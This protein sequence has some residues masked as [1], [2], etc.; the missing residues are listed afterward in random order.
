MH[1]VGLVMSTGVGLAKDTWAFTAIGPLAMI[2]FRYSGQ[3]AGEDASRVKKDAKVEQEKID[4]SSAV[5][6]V[7]SRYKAD[8]ILY[9]FRLLTD[10]PNFLSSADERATVEARGLRLETRLGFRLTDGFSA[11]VLIPLMQVSRHALVDE[12]DISDASGAAVHRLSP[13]ET[14]GLIG[15]A[16]RSLVAFVR[17]QDLSDDA[18]QRS[19][20]E[21]L[22]IACGLS[23]R[24]DQQKDN[25][26]CDDTG[27]G[28]H[29]RK[30]NVH[31]TDGE[32]LEQ[33]LNQILAALGITDK[34]WKDRLREFCTGLAKSDLVVVEVERP[35]QQGINL[36]YSQL[37]T[38]ESKR[39]GKLWR[40]RLGLA[41]DT[42]D[43]P[44]MVYVGHAQSYDFQ[45]APLAG[46]Y[47]LNHDVQQLRGTSTE[48]REDIESS[49]GSIDLY[50]NASPVRSHAH[51][52]ITLRD[53]PRMRAT[54]TLKDYKSV[55]DYRE[56][57]PG[58]L[59]AVALMSSAT[60]LLTTFFALSGRD[61]PELNPTL[62][63]AL[64]AFMV[65][66]LGHWWDTS[67]LPKSSVSA[68]L[69]MLGIMVISMLGALL[70]LLSPRH[71]LAWANVQPKVCCGIGPRDTNWLWL[72]LAA[73][74]LWLTLYLWL[75]LHQSSREYRR[76]QQISARADYTAEAA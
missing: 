19:V 64:P 50:K 20:E 55:V 71:V 44:P 1:A 53:P 61:G 35:K 37:L 65:I 12:L 6:A 32:D 34:E 73:F 72:T 3:F 18:A 58:A 67:R 7:L 22:R 29:E 74:A 14:R 25:G 49:L 26:E 27:G 56:T 17:S 48:T 46:Q 63:I 39:S 11:T 31:G 16:V 15:W 59:G 69:G 47:V 10:L 57:P 13:Y 70:Y 5:E 54:R 28:E 33:R 36:S 76:R 75:R 62:L 68:F 42:I 60:T 51:C 38:Y 43:A 45:L 24:P 23:L 41:P 4:V 21:L 30:E 52:R 9:F 66:V 8:A 2:A 40:T